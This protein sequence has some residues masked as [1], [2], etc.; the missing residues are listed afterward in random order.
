MTF[1]K[2]TPEDN[3]IIAGRIRNR[4]IEY[5]QTFSSAEGALKYQTN[6]P[7]AQVSAELFCDWEDNFHQD[8]IKNGFFSAPV[9]SEQ[10]LEVLV[11]LD[12]IIDQISH[13]IPENPPYITEFVK[14]KEFTLLS[15]A[16][17]KVLKILMIRGP[18]AKYDKDRLSYEVRS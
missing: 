2:P 7:I 14:T 8:W 18:N 6:V 16:I 4:I 9:F 11:D 5:L 3:V 1:P 12:K 10:E 15:E 13:Q 17:S